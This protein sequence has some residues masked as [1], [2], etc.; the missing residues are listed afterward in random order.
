MLYSEH[1]DEEILEL[2][3]TS[4]GTSTPPRYSH[5]GLGSHIL[6]AACGHKGLA[7]ENNGRGRFSTALLKL[8]REV[9]HNT[10]RYSDVLN[11]PRLDR[12]PQYL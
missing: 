5:I 7:Y 12:L 6:F 9:P 4:R 8:L 10:L 3:T 11:H 2:E 1:L